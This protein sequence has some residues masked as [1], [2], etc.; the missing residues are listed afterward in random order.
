MHF[1]SFA[2][3]VLLYPALYTYVGPDLHRHHATGSINPRDIND[4]PDTWWRLVGMSLV[5]HLVMPT[6][7]DPS[8]PSLE[9]HQLPYGTFVLH[10]I[11]LT[12][13]LVGFQLAHRL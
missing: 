12:V 11:V 3:A 5:P 9:E 7:P 1:T 10:V 8:I 6:Q 13:Y 4:A 2:I